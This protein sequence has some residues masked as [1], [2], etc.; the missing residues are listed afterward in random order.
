MKTDSRSGVGTAVGQHPGH[1]EP[2]LDVGVDQVT[3]HVVTARGDLA[4]FRGER[5]WRSGERVEQGDPPGRRV[6]VESPHPAQE[7]RDADPARNP[8]LVGRAFRVVEPAVWSA[9]DGWH[10][11]L[12]QLLQPRRVVTEPLHGH[13]QQSLGRR[14]GDGERVT[15]P[16]VLGLDVDQGELTRHEV[17]RPPDRMQADLHH[18]IAEWS[19]FEAPRSRAATG[20]TGRAAPGTRRRPARPRRPRRRTTAAPETSETVIRQ[21]ARGRRTPRRTSRS[22]GAAAA[23]GRYPPNTERTCRIPGASLASLIVPRSGRGTTDCHRGRIAHN[24]RAT[25]PQAPTAP[26][27]PPYR[28]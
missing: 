22:A 2:A 15:V 28:E 16:P 10:A 14:A 24:A 3:A 17:D 27:V 7:R 20:R 1:R 9:D 11:G 18:V 19:H 13:P 21:A 4:K 8:H 23:T 12:E 6:R 5:C 25:I 26:S